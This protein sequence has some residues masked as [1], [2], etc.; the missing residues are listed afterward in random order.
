VAA[1]AGIHIKQKHNQL[2]ANITATGL[3]AAQPC[4]MPSAADT[5]AA[6]MHH[7]CGVANAA[8]TTKL[9]QHPLPTP[10]CML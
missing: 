4:S 10:A 7:R 9:P 6:V 1:A 8:N 3:D 2:C 5:L